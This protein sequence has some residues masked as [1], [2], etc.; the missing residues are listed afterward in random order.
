MNNASA[1]DCPDSDPDAGNV[2]VRAEFPYECPGDWAF[3]GGLVWT[4]TESCCTT[5][6]PDDP[7]ATALV[8]FFCN[9]PKPHG[10]SHGS[11][12]CGACNARLCAIDIDLYVDGEV[13]LDGDSEEDPFGEQECRANN[14]AWNY[15]L[16]L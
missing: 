12:A 1:S 13:R 16:T 5:Q 7:A 4:C 2:L 9:D 11:Y 3:S 10:P 8:N 14:V 15:L 6:F